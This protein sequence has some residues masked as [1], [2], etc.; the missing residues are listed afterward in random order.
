MQRRL[1][2]IV[3]LGSSLCVLV[4][5]WQ[6]FRDTSLQAVDELLRIF[7]DEFVRWA[8]ML[9]A[10]TLI[11]GLFNLAQVHANRIIKRDEGWSYSVI[12]L[13]TVV[14]MLLAGLNGSNTPAVQW[15]FRYVQAPLHATLLSLVVFFIFSAAWRAFRTHSAG[16]FVMFLTAVIVLLGQIPLSEEV[17]GLRFIQLQQW[18]VN[19]PNIA[20]HRGMLLGIAIGIIITGLRLLMGMYHKRLFN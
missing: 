4:G 14:F 17:L 12:L 15:I 7:S 8:G 2:L 1:P 19:V 3:M 16:M 6:L 11:L 20:G 5:Q 13:A 10:F 9:F 18:I